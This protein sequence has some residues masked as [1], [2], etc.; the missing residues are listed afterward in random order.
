MYNSCEKWNN[1]KLFLSK[2]KVCY[3]NGYNNLKIKKDK[4]LDLKLF[5]VLVTYF[6][7]KKY[8]W[9]KKLSN[10]KLIEEIIYYPI[11]EFTD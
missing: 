5:S 3:N 6:L 9:S 4:S 7:T 10:D 11:T 1:W 2:W 8:N